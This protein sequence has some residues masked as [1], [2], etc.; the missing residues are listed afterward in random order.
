[1]GRGSGGPKPSAWKKFEAQKLKA[2]FARQAASKAEL[3]LSSGGG[4]AELEWVYSIDG[5]ETHQARVPIGGL[6]KHLT[7]GVTGTLLSKG[8]GA[9]PGAAPQL[10]V[11]MPAQGRFPSSRPTQPSQPH[12]RRPQ[13][14]V[15]IYA[16]S[17]AQSKVDRCTL[18]IS[19]CQWLTCDGRWLGQV[20]DADRCTA[21]PRTPWWATLGCT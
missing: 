10:Q 15:S 4:A 1:M 14:L 8:S 18:S 12:R 19:A 21:R 2:F 16:R 3:Q 9:E 20:V 6:V 13:S 17:K 7:F 5:D 11:E